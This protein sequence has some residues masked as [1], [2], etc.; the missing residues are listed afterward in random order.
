M[1]RI[2]YSVGGRER[3]LMAFSV[4]VLLCG[5]YYVASRPLTTNA[6]SR[7][8]IYALKSG[9]LSEIPGLFMGGEPIDSRVAEILQ[10]RVFGTAFVP[11]QIKSLKTVNGTDGRA[12]TAAQ[13]VRPDGTTHQFILTSVETPSGPR[14]NLDHVI[15]ETWAM[16]G[17]VSVFES[18]SADVAAAL[19]AGLNRDRPALEA[20]GLKGMYSL[21]NQFRTWDE[22][23]RDFSPQ[24]SLPLAGN[25][26]Q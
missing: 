10:Q 5:I 1:R 6:E 3:F 18:P 22:L 7:N 20:C 17:S 9:R 24:T 2:R 12:V 23:E 19:L 13:F 4:V 8:A 14:I 26:D 15:Y 11:Y 16:E 25:S 21:H